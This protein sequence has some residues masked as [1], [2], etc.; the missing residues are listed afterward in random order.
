MI[1]QERFPGLSTRT[2]SAYSSDLSVLRLCAH[3]PRSP[4][5]GVSE[6]CGGF[7]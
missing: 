5:F 6:Q 7:V 4:S 1:A 2:F 3:S